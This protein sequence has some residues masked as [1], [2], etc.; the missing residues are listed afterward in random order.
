[1]LDFFPSVPAM[2]GDTVYEAPSRL[3][4][5]VAKSP[6]VRAA[7]PGPGA[8][9][10]ERIQALFR[11]DFLVGGISPTYYISRW[12]FLRLLGLVHLVAFVS[13]WYQLEGLVGRNGVT[14][15]GFFLDYI[16]A[17]TDW[18]RFFRLPT[19]FWLNHSDVVLH[20]VCALGTVAAVVLVADVLPAV[21]LGVLFVCY[22]SFV[23]VTPDFL[24]FQWDTLLLETTFLAIF[25]APAKLRPGIGKE[26]VHSRVMLMLLRWLL[27]RLM[28]MSGVV[29]FWNPRDTSWRDLTALSYHYETQPLPHAVSWYAHQLPMWVDKVSTASTFAIEV[30]LPFAMLA[31]RRVR[32]AL[33][34]CFVFFQLSIA[35]SGNYTF[36]NLLTIALCLLLLDDRHWKFIAPA[37]LKGIITRP[38][39]KRLPFYRKA[40]MGGLGIGLVT[41]SGLQM[42]LVLNLD[43]PDGARR[44]VYH[45]DAYH[46]ANRYGLFS[47]MTKTRQEIV[48]EGSADGIT[49]EPYEFKWK[50]G[51]LDRRPGW[52]QPYQP[53]LDWQM[54]FAPFSPQAPPWFKNFA[55]RLLEGK[56]EVL[57]LLERNPFPLEPPKYLRAHVYEYRFTTPEQ[58][59][60]TG[61][62]WTRTYIGEYPRTGSIPHEL[63]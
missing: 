52:A 50:P 43:L 23:S 25:F 9:R 7:V 2:K 34:L 39:L 22:L 31:P 60:R 32:A 48:I 27:F 35:A 58:Y 54:W 10:W 49:W 18:T 14:P 44:L 63:R 15:A 1:M 29:K 38:P 16:S 17:R 61:Q 62:W 37:W 41:L 30:L 13:L 36:F 8:T 56:P 46:I 12:L 6:A 40:L 3:R 26:E 24:G 47:T 19:V 11:R 20:V 33:C 28:F 42:C 45:S 5:E 51:R 59:A 21:C 53:R 57:A 4:D 55:Y